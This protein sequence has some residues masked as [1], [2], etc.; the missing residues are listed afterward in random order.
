MSIDAVPNITSQVDLNA[1]FYREH[2]GLQYSLSHELLEGHTFDPK[3]RI[4][5]VG[6]GD[7]RIT[8]EIAY[9]YAPEGTVTGI[10]ASPSMITLAKRVF[11]QSMVPNLDFLE[12][13]VEDVSFG[14]EFDAI[15][16]FSCLHWISSPQ[17]NLRT[18]R[19]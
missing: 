13:R 11:S 3:A 14:S 2:S 18:H 5:D 7:G 10:D 4:L 17:L 8:A 12:S 6:C 16:S 19:A 1:L 9:R 15:V